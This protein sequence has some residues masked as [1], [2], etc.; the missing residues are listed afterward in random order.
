V[1]E[2]TW[3]GEEANVEG[4]DIRSLLS[5]AAEDHVDLLKVD[6]EG[7]EMELFGH[8]ASSWL[9]KIRNICIELHGQDCKEAFERALQHFQYDR[10]CSGDLVVCR[11]L[12]PM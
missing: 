1:R 4:W 5:L 3:P 2:R 11:N 10:S 8:N 7:S 12:R 6:I 9:P